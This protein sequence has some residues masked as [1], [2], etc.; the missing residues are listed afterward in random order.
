VYA[1]KRHR[2]ERVG[3]V[4]QRVRIVLGIE[5]QVAGHGPR[6]DVEASPQAVAL[7]HVIES[8]LL[9]ARHFRVEQRMDAQVELEQVGLEER[10]APAPA[11]DLVAQRQD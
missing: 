8:R 2:V 9:E 3:L 10:Q 1:G 4:R 6:Q 7:N 11:L 5:R